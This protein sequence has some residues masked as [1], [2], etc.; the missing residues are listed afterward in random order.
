MNAPE[1]VLYQQT[2]KGVVPIYADNFT[3]QPETYPKEDHE[4]WGYLLARQKNV[5]KERAHPLFLKY[6]DELSFSSHI[7]RFSALEEKL[8]G[9]KLVPVNGLLSD[10]VFFELLAQKKFPTTWWMRPQNQMEYIQE[11]D[12]FHD[13]FGH[14]PFLMNEEYSSLVQNFGRLGSG[15][16]SKSPEFMVKLARLY[17]FTIEFGLYKENTKMFAAGAGL[18][19][20]PSEIIHS[21]DK[22][23]PKK[24]FSQKKAA[25]TDYK[26]DSYQ[27]S[28]FYF[29]SFADVEKE[30]RLFL[31]NEQNSSNYF[32]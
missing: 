13:V 16:L 29:S 8:K 11:P 31:D 1:K 7:P 20:S 32:K 17:W 9:W 10:Q 26:I 5:A 2:D 23:T 28:Y 4:T 15:A 14:I 6:L 25:V 24:I 21:L 30:L 3:N 27:P 18:L 19:S 22:G 12:M